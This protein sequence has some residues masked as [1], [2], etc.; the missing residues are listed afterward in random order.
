MEPQDNDV[1]D[2]FY[3]SWGG[4]DAA[5]DR[6]AAGYGVTSNIMNIL[7]L[8]YRQRVPMTQNELSREL[9]LSKQTVTSVLD[10]LEKRDLI[11]RSIAEGD[12]RSRVVTLTEEGRASGRQMGRTMRSVEVS[13]FAMLTDEEQH[14]MVDGM[15]KLWHGFAH[16]LD[17]E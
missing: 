14:A 13:A 2:R 17:N 6:I 10:S 4:I 3:K 7:T 8:L 1:F 12:R 9:Y 16:I 11:I 5:Y 15:E